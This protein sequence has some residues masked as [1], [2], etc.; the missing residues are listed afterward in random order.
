MFPKF[1]KYATKYLTV[2]YG[3]KNC[4]ETY[5]KIGILKFE[6]LAKDDL[7]TIEDEAGKY[8]ELKTVEGQED[9]SKKIL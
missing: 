8:V 2:A 4:M 5:A 6:L 1:E 3:I 9:E 7:L